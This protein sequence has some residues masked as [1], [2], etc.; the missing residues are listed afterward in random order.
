MVEIPKCINIDRMIEER[1]RRAPPPQFD[2]LYENIKRK[3]VELGR[4]DRRI[5]LPV[6]IS[7]IKPNRY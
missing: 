1:I 6:L 2:K 5:N 7:H 3:S 4:D